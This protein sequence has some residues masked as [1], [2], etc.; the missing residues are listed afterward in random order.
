MPVNTVHNILVALVQQAH[1]YLDLTQSLSP[2]IEAHTVFYA[3]CQ[4]IFYIITYLSNKLLDNGGYEYLVSLQLDRLVTCRLNPLK[5]CCA[6]VADAFANVVDNLGVVSISCM[7]LVERN[8]SVKFS[9]NFDEQ[10]PLRSYFPFDPLF[11]D[12]PLTGHFIDPFYNRSP[13]QWFEDDD[14]HTDRET[15]RESMSE[16]SASV[17]ASI[18][19]EA[20]IGSLDFSSSARFSQG[21]VGSSY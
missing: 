11:Q 17:G 20:R 2:N 19:F 1:T 21:S 16:A 12:L 4:A 8:R 3:V 14:D 7:D 15:S 13:D 6:S 18:S 5:F 10:N 9:L